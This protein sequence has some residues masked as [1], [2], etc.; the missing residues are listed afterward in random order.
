MIRNNVHNIKIT[1][2]SSIMAIYISIKVIGLGISIRVFFCSDLERAM[3][4]IPIL[5]SLLK[6]T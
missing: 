3:G 1:C 5:S 2:Q 6:L 4:R